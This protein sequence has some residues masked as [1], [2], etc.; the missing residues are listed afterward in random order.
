MADLTE[1]LEVA[2]A[3]RNAI[4]WEIGSGGMATVYLAEDLEHE[5]KLAVKVPPPELVAALGA[6]PFPTA[7]KS[8]RTSSSHTSYRCSTPLKAGGFLYGVMP[9]EKRHSLRGK[10]ATEGKLRM[11]LLGFSHDRQGSGVSGGDRSNEGES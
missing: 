11:S 8:P 4:D 5:R 3:D 6:E 7:S 9:Y 10:L 1:Q 2:L